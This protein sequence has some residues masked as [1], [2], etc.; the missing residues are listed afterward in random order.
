MKKQTNLN[1]IWSNLAL[2]RAAETHT[3]NC[4]IA[5]VAKMTLACLQLSVTDV[6]KAETFSK[7][8]SLVE[9]HSFPPIRAIQ[10]W[11][12]EIHR[13]TEETDANTEVLTGKNT[14]S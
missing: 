11:S 3:I 5:S 10:T 2:I 7:Y 9:K 14:G 6:V 1:S 13:R 12:E 8:L 4:Q